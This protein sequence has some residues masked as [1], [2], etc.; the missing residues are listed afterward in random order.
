MRTKAENRQKQIEAIELAKQGV[1][2]KKIAQKLG[3]TEK[4][5]GV[6]LKPYKDENHTRTNI[7]RLFEVR[8]KC[9]LSETKPDF[10][11]VARLTKALN[12]YK[13]G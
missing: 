9:L 4:T 12:E 2:Q 7:I 8:L 5:V 13:R 6:W 11:E 1:Q 3:V 10:L